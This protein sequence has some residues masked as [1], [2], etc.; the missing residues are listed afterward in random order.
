MSRH[1]W[2]EWV[3]S[4]EVRNL[5]WKSKGS[6]KLAWESD[7]KDPKS[8]PLD[9]LAALAQIQALVEDPRWPR[10]LRGR[11]PKPKIPRS[12]AE[13]VSEKDVKAI[14][15]ESHSGSYEDA[16]ARA[17]GTNHEE[18]DES[19]KVFK[20]IL[21]AM[22]AAYLVGHFGMELLPKPK[23]SILHRRLDEIA[24]AAGIGDQ[25]QKGFAE[26]LDDLCPCGLKSH[27]EALRK[28]SSRYPPIRRPKR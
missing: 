7:K 4:P 22:E 3:E 26:F 17:A 2:A 27:G 14:W 28:L 23:V 21:R 20:G 13:L 19:C 6:L 12:L 15:E 18:V 5:L 9:T 11:L 8:Y 10:F 25:T 24:K 16:L 1:A